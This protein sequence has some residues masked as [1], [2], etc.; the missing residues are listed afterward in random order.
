VWWEF[1]KNYTKLLKSTD[2]CTVYVEKCTKSVTV[3]DSLHL[4]LEHD[5]F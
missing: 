2:E 3:V 1:F 5:D 4:T